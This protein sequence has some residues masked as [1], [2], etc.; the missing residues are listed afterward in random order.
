MVERS[1]PIPEVCSSNQVIS[2]IYIE[3][4]FTVKCQLYWKDGNKEFAFFKNCFVFSAI[5]ICWIAESNSGPFELK[6]IFVGADAIASWFS[7][8][9]PSCSPGFEHHLWF[10]QFKLLKL[11]LYCCW[12][13][14]RTKIK[15]IE[16]GI[17]HIFK[18]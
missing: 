4:L 18:K 7:L 3:H 15:E 8:R 10:F 1:L 9:L 2:K 16:A 11:K 14:K 5:Y 6:V 17:S 12:N 13:K